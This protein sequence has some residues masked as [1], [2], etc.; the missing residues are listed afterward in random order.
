MKGHRSGKRDEGSPVSWA[1]RGLLP[2][3]QQV[4]DKLHGR[5][6]DVPPVAFPQ[7]LDL[8]GNVLDVGLAETA[9]AQQMSASL[10]PLHEVRVVEALHTSL[11]HTPGRHGAAGA[12]CYSHLCP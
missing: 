10:S 9:G 6:I 8:P 2:P 5:S 3:F 12:P 7:V 11:D 1:A 4:S